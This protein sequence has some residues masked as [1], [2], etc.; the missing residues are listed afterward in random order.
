MNAKDANRQIITYM[1]THKL[2]VLKLTAQTKKK[3]FKDLGNLEIYAIK[4]PSN[5]PYDLPTVTL[6]DLILL[7]KYNII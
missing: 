2:S 4:F 5:G 3:I 7:D 1:L 6:E